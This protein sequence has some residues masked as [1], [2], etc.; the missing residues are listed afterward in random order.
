M[1]APVYIPTFKKIGELLNG[2]LADSTGV[3]VVNYRISGTWG[4]QGSLD[5]FFAA[6]ALVH[7]AARG[8]ALDLSHL[9][10]P[11]FA[12]DAIDLLYVKDTGRAIAHLQLADQLHHRTYNVG[13]GRATSN[14]ELVDAIT[15]VVP[16][17]R[18]GLP[19]GGGAAPLVLDVTRLQQDSGYRPEY[20][21]DAAIADYI[22]WL[23]AG[24][25][26]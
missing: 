20:D 13:S 10:A 8:T 17:A 16:D 14:T 1:D 11:V 15:Q 21:T 3:D 25:A 23:R 26:R 22:G 4:P 12:E 7:A 19:T 9:L 6:P 5:P 2:Y 24:H 18:L